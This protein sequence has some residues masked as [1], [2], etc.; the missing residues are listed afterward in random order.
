MS[1]FA[2]R[3]SQRVTNNMYRYS[4]FAILTLLA[5][6]S[7]YLCDVMKHIAIRNLQFSTCA[8]YLRIANCELRNKTH[9]ARTANRDWHDCPTRTREWDFSAHMLDCA[10]ELR[11]WWR[12]FGKQV[13]Q[14]ENCECGDENFQVKHCFA[15]IANM[16][17]EILG[18]A[19]SNWGCS[20]YRI[21][22]SIANVSYLLMLF[23]R[24]F[25]QRLPNHNDRSMEN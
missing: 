7:K 16:N 12:N 17:K 5:S 9:Q 21:T 15:R 14:H 20:Y 6:C 18:I 19:N 8:L 22:L 25:M 13:Q 3:N 2:I 1:L 24:F 10:W 4:Q 23:N 11:M